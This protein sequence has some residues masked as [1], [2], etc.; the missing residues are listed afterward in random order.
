MFWICE[1]CDTSNSTKLAECEVCETPR[2]AGTTGSASRS[3]ARW[4]DPPRRTT[5]SAARRRYEPEIRV[6]RAERSATG[7]TLA[8]RRGGAILVAA[9]FLFY[10]WPNVFG[11]AEPVRNPLTPIAP[12]PASAPGSPAAGDNAAPA[13]TTTE[14][15]LPFPPNMT[16]SDITAGGDVRIRDLASIVGC[17]GYATREPM[18]TVTAEVAAVAQ[19][20]AASQG[21]VSLAVRG[22]AGRWYCAGPG[23]SGTSLL[24]IGKAA[25]GRYDVWVTTR[26]SE[27]RIPARL[28]SIILPA[29]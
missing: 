20:H 28:A 13:P 1:V 29:S 3:S 16:I 19:F 27:D 5:S 14:T 15:G 25:P 23:S 6:V 26:S 24:H 21:S 12:P 17:D 4:P 9:T 18:A 11:G 10:V 8:I 7:R 2:T 22:P